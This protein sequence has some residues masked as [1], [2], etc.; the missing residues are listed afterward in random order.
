MDFKAARTIVDKIRHIVNPKGYDWLLK[1]DCIVNSVDSDPSS[2]TFGTCNVTPINDKS[3]SPIP[4]VNLQSSIGD[5]ILAFPV[6]D[7]QI[8]LLGSDNTPYIV[9]AFQDIDFLYISAETK[10]QFNKGLNGGLVDVVP[11]TT[12]L[13]NIESLLN[14]FITIYNTHVHTANN[15]PTLQVETGSLTPT[16]QNEIEDTAVTH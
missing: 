2:P 15:T 6:L 8:T 4:N 5:G 3:T 1:I 12:K 9:I 14:G 10:V 16:N 7:S 13:N 11:L